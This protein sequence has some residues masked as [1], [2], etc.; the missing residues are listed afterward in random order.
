MSAA[1]A[2]AASS[3]AI[4]A[5]S[6]NQ[7]IAAQM[8]ECEDYVKGYQHTTVEA[9]AKYADCIELL[10]PSEISVAGIVLGVLFIALIVYGVFFDHY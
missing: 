4:A 2:I 10:N 1:A 6:S 9:A 8:A 3:A 7:N 5:S